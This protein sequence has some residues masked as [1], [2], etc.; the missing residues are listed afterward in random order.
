VLDPMLAAEP[1]LAADVVFGIR[2]SL[3]LADR[4]GD[5]LLGCWQ[6]GRTSL[7]APLDPPP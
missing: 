1:D 5:H 3:M 2:A 7:L 4:L 6:R